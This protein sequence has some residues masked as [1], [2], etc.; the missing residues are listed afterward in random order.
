MRDEG[1]CEEANDKDLKEVSEEWMFQKN[2][3]EE[4]RPTD[5]FEWRSKKIFSIY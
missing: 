5:I 2:R 1:K 3:N 4:W